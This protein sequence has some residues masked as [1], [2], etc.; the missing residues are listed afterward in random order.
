MYQWRL[1][2]E[3]LPIEKRFEQMSEDPNTI[4]MHLQ[5]LE[6]N[7]ENLLFI[8]KTKTV[9]KYVEFAQSNFV[10]KKFKKFVV[11][12][13]DTLNFK[14]DECDNVNIFWVRLIS[15]FNI[16]TLRKFTEFL[17]E[18]ELD[19]D[20]NYEVKTYNEVKIFENK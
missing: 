18:E 10:Q 12:S 4:K 16:G 15:N 20:L 11:F 7:A 13:K 6:K 5:H 2:F 8:A 14:C 1:S 19:L 17:K 9:E 3:R